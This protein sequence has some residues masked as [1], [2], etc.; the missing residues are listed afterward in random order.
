MST[1]TQETKARSR[2]PLDLT[3]LD[4]EVLTRYV[5]ETGKMLP[6]KITRFSAKQQR[7]ITRQI[8]RA[9]NLL[10]MK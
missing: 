2:S 10:L 9:R 6:R 8:K 7:H 3:F 4:A 5:T 1:A